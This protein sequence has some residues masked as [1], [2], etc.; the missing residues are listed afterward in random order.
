MS[1]PAVT[2]QIRQLE[3][4][5]NVRLFERAHNCICLTDA[6]KRV[7]GYTEKIFQLYTEMED[8]VRKVSNDVNDVLMLGVSTSAAEYMFP[9]LLGA[10]K[11][12]HPDVNIQLKVANTDSIVSQ[13]K[14]NTIDLGVVEPPVNNRNLV[15]ENYIMDRFVLIVP[16]EHALAKRK[17]VSVSEL[18]D[19]PVICHKQDQK[20]LNAIT[21]S[22]LDVDISVLDLNIVME[23][24][25]LDAVKQAI[26]AGQGISILPLSTT[27]S[28]LKQGN[29]VAVDI[30]PPISPSFSF[31]HQK[32]RFYP[33][34]MDELL[35]FARDY[36][37]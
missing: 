5:F 8:V 2:F 11:Q 15:V 20:T 24:D 37:W 16:S 33:R 35:S 28:A 19:Y 34:A 13:I 10:F 27:R 6:G 3:E 12:R 23:L 32:Q 31:I 36:A 17:N 26:S 29:F 25:S 30:N 1:Q 14:N 18:A 7:L 22:M 9:S 21:E 4:H